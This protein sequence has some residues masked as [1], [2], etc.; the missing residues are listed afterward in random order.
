MK[1]GGGVAEVNAHHT[2][3]DFAAVPV[4]LPGGAH[5]LL[6]AFGRARLVHA[7]DG[8]RMR[9]FGS[10]DLLTT[11]SQLLFVPFDRF[12]KT[13]QRPR[14]GTE[15]NGHGFSIFALHIGELSL[16]IDLQQ[17]PSFSS[18]E[19]ISEQR[20]KQRQLPSQCQNLL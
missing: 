12:K 3:L 7:A 10:H 2:V 16:N 8:F 19:T 1:A 5:G 20:Q 17:I 9:V 6:A 18:H 13:L 11:I 14:R 4:V 15:F